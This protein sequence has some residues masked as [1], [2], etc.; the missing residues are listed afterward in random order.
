MYSLRGILDAGG[1]SP[2]FI[3]L[4]VTIRDK[5]IHKRIQT[6]TGGI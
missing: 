6:I 5:D 2:V 4:F 3:L 1:N